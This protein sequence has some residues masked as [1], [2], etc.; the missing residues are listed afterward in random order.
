[1]ELEQRVAMLE[2]RVRQLQDKLGTVDNRVE[3]LWAVPAIERLTRGLLHMGSKEWGL[4]V[5]GQ[6]YISKVFNGVRYWLV[7]RTA[8]NVAVWS[9]T[10]AHEV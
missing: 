1:M 8:D 9:T 10:K 5:D 6:A 2:E 3:N 4:L 7:R